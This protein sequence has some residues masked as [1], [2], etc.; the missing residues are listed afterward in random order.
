MGKCEPVETVNDL[1]P[2][3]KMSITNSPLDGSVDATPCG[4]IAKYYFTGKVSYV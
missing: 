1:K 2:D 4:L 3:Q